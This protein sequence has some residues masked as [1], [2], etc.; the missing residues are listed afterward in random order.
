MKHL[1]FS[2]ALIAAFASCDQKKEETPKLNLED[3]STKLTYSLAVLTAN[4]LKNFKDQFEFF[5]DSVFMQGLQE[6]FDE[7][8]QMDMMT[9]QQNLTEYSGKQRDA[10]MGDNLAEGEE[11]MAENAEKEGVQTTQSGIQYEVLR[12]GNGPKPS[13]NDSVKMHYHGTLVDGTVFDSS[14]DRNEPIV[15]NVDGFIA[16]WTEILQMMPVGAKYRVVIPYNLAYGAQGGG[17]IPPY[18]TL[19]FEM[20]L[21]EI[22]K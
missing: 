4:D 19:I 14:I 2:A 20:E 18:A 7:K 15:H 9:A 3:E 21:L 12:E 13:A 11:F 17:P 1:L 5:D 10:A 6:A 8:A 22:V 16:G